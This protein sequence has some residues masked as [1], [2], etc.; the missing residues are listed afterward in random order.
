MKCE[1]CKFLTFFAGIDSGYAFCSKGLA[2]EKDEGCPGFEPRNWVQ[3]LADKYPACFLIMAI[4]SMLAGI[5]GTAVIVKNFGWVPWG[6][7]SA[8]IWSVSFLVS[9]SILL[10]GLVAHGG[11]DID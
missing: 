9:F 4:V 8:G 7:V 11:Y 2:I 3:R 10:H 5:V 1:K 6:W